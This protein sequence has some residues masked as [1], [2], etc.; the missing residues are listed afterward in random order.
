MQQG[1]RGHCASLFGPR[2]GGEA[3]RG[4]LRAAQSEDHLPR[5]RG[6]DLPLIHALC[7]ASRTA[8]PMFMQPRAAPSCGATR[9]CVLSSTTSS[10]TRSTTRCAPSPSALA[11]LAS[12]SCLPPLLAT[13]PLTSPL[14]ASAHARPLC[15]SA[16]RS[17][18]SAGASGRALEARGGGRSRRRPLEAEAREH[19]LTHREAGRRSAAAAREQARRS[20]LPQPPRHPLR[21]SPPLPQ[22]PTA[23]RRRRRRPRRGP[24]RDHGAEPGRASEGRPRGAV[25]PRRRSRRGQRGS[26]KG[27]VRAQCGRVNEDV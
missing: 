24:P 1:A 27:S 22:L 13:H 21:P 17:W 9:G 15:A 10:S 16:H 3:A 25:G 7:L 26:V 6:F 14:C 23:G 2:S 20:N 12:R 5:A 4:R 18:R 8:G 19:R 11:C